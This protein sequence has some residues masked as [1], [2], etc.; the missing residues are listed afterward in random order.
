MFKYLV[1]LLL[2]K[3]CAISAGTSEGTLDGSVGFQRTWQEYCNGFGSIYGEFFIGLEKLHWLTKSRPYELYVELVDFGN[4]KY[5]AQYDNFLIGSEQEKYM[6]KSLGN[7]TGDAGD[8]LTYNLHDK[9][10]TLDSDNDKW[11]K[12]NC[13]NWYEGGGWFNLYGNR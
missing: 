7:Y 8:A 5:Y 6:L 12:G 2:L 9:F 10:T 3:Y 13:A 1:Y 11:P 4:Q